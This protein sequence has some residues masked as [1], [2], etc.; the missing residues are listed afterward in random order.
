MAGTLPRN[1]WRPLC[2]KKKELKPKLVWISPL[3]KIVLTLGLVTDAKKLYV[4]HTVVWSFI[5]IT[6]KASYLFCVYKIFVWLLHVYQPTDLF[7]NTFNYLNIH[8]LVRKG[9]HAHTHRKWERERERERE[10]VSEWVSEWEER[11]GERNSAAGGSIVLTSSS[12]SIDLRT[13]P[14]I[15]ECHVPVGVT[16]CMK[17]F[18]FYKQ[19][20]QKVYAITVTMCT[21]VGLFKFCMLNKDPP[22]TLYRSSHVYP[23]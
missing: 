11:E 4:W 16:V 1:N 6:W 19:T 10:W 14:S 20:H 12:A 9:L 2:L 17:N 8:I 18:I 3:K 21:I 13:V 22:K 5:S 23:M 7:H 15:R